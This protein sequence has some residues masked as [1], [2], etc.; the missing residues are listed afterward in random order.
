MVRVA[1][2]VSNWLVVVCISP[3]VIEGVER[4]DAELLEMSELGRKLINPE[5][6]G[7]GLDIVGG[8]GYDSAG[9]REAGV[10][11]VTKNRSF[12]DARESLGT[13]RMRVLVVVEGTLSKAQMRPLRSTKKRGLLPGPGPI[14][15][16]WSNRRFGKASTAWMVCPG[17]TPGAG[18]TLPL[19]NGNMG[20]PAARP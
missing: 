1:V 3:Y 17:G 6:E 19:R 20:S 10:G 4:I 7:P 12:G 15:T 18:G 13:S 2:E 14:H 9:C 16:G 11:F 5:K 8:G